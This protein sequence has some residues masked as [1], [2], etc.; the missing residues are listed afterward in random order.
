LLAYVFTTAL[1]GLA[2][3]WLGTLLNLGIAAVTVY[4]WERRRLPLMPIFLAVVYVLFFQ[5][6]KHTFRV[7]Y[8]YSGAAP[9]G[10]LDR[11]GT[12]G[13]VALD[14]WEGAL[15]NPA[16]GTA[17]DLVRLTIMRASL[18]T[19]TGH[20]VQSTPALVPYQGG[21]TYSYLV[22]GLVP[23][24]LWPD[25]P[26]VNDA[27]RYYQT[28]YGLTLAQNLNGVSISVGSLAE[29]YINFGWVGVIIVMFFLGILFDFV[30][31]TFLSQAAGQFLGAL[32]IVILLHFLVIESQLAL[33]LSG[34]L[35]TGLLATVVLLPA[36]RFKVRRPEALK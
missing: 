3:G 12:W 17:L 21:S 30:Q 11:A 19:Q 27:N 34:I 16:S 22:T 32:G 15:S 8:L 18:L 6:G 4:L 14:N 5:A 20:V 26:S 1:N 13:R 7:D 2:S 25:K 33:Y 10:K 36:L 9:V 31:T 24:F 29:A 23:R 28:A 35:Q